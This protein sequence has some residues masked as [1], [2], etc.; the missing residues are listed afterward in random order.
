M[1]GIASYHWSRDH[2]KS[3]RTTENLVQ[4]EDQLLPAEEQRCATYTV[5]NKLHLVNI[6]LHRSLAC[7]SILF[8]L[9]L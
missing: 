2:A 3:P 6:C 9:P 8:Y 7:F 4:S 1:V 5:L